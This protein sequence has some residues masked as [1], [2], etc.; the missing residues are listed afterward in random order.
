MILCRKKLAPVAGVALVLF[1]ASAGQAS[2]QMAWT[3]RAFLNASIGQ[4]W[5]DQQLV[6]GS[7][8]E[9]YDETANWEAVMD[10][11]DSI[12][13]DVSA[14]YR[15]WKN[16]AIAVGYSRTSDTGDTSL[17]AVIP[18]TLRFDTP[19]HD[20]RELT[21][22]DREESVVHVSAVW[23]VPVTDKIDIA[24]MAGPSFF[25]VKQ[26]FLSDITVTP[27]GTTIGTTT[28]GEISD[29]AQGYHV[30]VDGAFRIIRNVGIGGM[31]RY[32]K[33]EVAASR[34]V[35][36]SLDVGGFQGL[37]GVRVRF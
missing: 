4:Q 25:S 30:A 7:S 3:D 36:G 15:V 16:L 26:T 11:D 9:I 18:D 24:L 28:D 22:Y 8:F 37:V 34:F 23:M 14:G 32:A 12:V 1:F 19:H 17:A 6:S 29:S 33:A 20:T 13:F 5:M 10:V 35:A 2:A 21:G 31:L 27:G